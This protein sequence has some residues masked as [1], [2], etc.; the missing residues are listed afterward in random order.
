MPKKDR[1]SFTFLGVGRLAMAS[2]FPGLHFIPSA[3]TTYPRSSTDG[4]LKV[5]LEAFSFSPFLSRASN[6]W[7][8]CSSCSSTDCENITISSRYTITNFP[9]ISPSTACMVR[10]NSAGALARPN[11]IRTN[12]YSPVWVMNAVFLISSS[13]TGICQYPLFKSRVL[14]TLAPER[15]SNISWMRGKGWASLRVIALTFLKSTQKRIDPSFFGT[16]VMGDAHSDLLGRITPSSSI[17][18]SS[19]STCFLL[20]SGVL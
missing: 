1:T 9:S 3:D 10:W 17:F 4:A 16:R 5:H 19:C 20:L 15:L 14:K 8:R 6:T 12:S 13:C 2:V 11:G 18:W 7:L